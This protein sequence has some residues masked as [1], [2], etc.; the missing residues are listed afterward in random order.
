MNIISAKL[1]YFSP[2]KTTKTVLESIAGALEVVNIDH[3]DLTPP[4][5]RT[6]RFEELREQY[7]DGLRWVISGPTIGAVAISP[8]WRSFIM[9]ITSYTS[10]R[11]LDSIY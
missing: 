7:S 4:D 5:A 6:R 11:N 8:A 9:R 10:I 3:L 2:T 1:V